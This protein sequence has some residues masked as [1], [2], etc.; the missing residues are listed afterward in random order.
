MHVLVTGGSGY[1]GQFLVRSAAVTDAC[2]F[3]LSPVAAVLTRSRL[4]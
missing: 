2:G 1:L 4:G 3:A